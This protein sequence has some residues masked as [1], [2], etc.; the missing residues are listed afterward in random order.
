MKRCYD[1]AGA[2]SLQKDYYET[3]GVPRDATD[4]DIKKAYYKLA[5]EYHPDT[6]K[7]CWLLQA[8]GQC[9]TL[10]RQAGLFTSCAITLLP[11]PSLSIMSGLGR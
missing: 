5:K 4:T 6:N 9:D 1:A 11:C 3:L 7:V 2:V 10:E 8:P